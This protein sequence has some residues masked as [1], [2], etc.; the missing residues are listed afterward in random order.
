MAENNNN[1]NFT[2]N[3]LLTAY[4]FLTPYSLIVIIVPNSS[5]YHP[6]V[7]WPSTPN[8]LH[9]HDVISTI[10]TTT[11][12]VSTNQRAAC[13]RCS[14]PIRRQS[15]D[16]WRHCRHSNHNNPGLVQS[17]SGLL[18]WFYPD[19]PAISWSPGKRYKT[20]FFP[21]KEKSTSRL[22]SISSRCFFF[23]L[24]CSRFC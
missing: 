23:L 2:L 13:C 11:I 18:P 6:A 14:I 21:Q 3:S 8:C 5:H 10:A 22:R 1:N 16:P 17:E 15:A 24:F 9:Q 20:D 19:Q 12:L 7:E 4:S